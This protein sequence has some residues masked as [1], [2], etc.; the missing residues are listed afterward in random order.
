MAVHVNFFSVSWPGPWKERELTWMVT[1][2]SSDYKPVDLIPF[3]HQNS[4]TIGTVCFTF[5]VLLIGSTI[6]RPHCLHK[7]VNVPKVVSGSLHWIP[8]FLWRRESKGRLV[9]NGGEQSY[10]DVI[11]YLLVRAL[12]KPFLRKFIVPYP[13]VSLSR[14]AWIKFSLT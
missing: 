1:S 3:R 10:S 2:S 11:T 6:V 4:M 9:G 5:Q 14:I 12:S 8:V 13:P 7:C